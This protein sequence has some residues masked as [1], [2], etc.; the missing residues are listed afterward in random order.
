M[1]VFSFSDIRLKISKAFDSFQSALGRASMREVL[2]RCSEGEGHEDAESEKLT[3]DDELDET[4][5]ETC[6]NLV[7][8][9][10][11]QVDHQRQEQGYYSGLYTALLQIKEQKMITDEAAAFIG[12]YL[13][14]GWADQYFAVC[15]QGSWYQIAGLAGTGFSRRWSLKGWII[16]YAPPGTMKVI[17]HHP[18]VLE[19]NFFGLGIEP[20]DHDDENDENESESEPMSSDEDFYLGSDLF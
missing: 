13:G 4:E 3:N 10:D 17:Q 1:E 16:K 8:L 11:Q 12:L 5:R 9:F 7:E 15:H 19:E 20:S 6:R 18:L 2:H 14:L